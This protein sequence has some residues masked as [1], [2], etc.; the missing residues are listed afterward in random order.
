LLERKGL[1]FGEI[2]LAG[3][4]ESA[5]S[6]KSKLVGLGD[7]VIPNQQKGLRHLIAPQ[8]ESIGR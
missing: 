2:P 5:P 4:N 8:P 6:R 7:L 1:S 3:Q